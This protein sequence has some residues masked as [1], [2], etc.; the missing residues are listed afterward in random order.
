M[1]KWRK[2]EKGRLY[3][4]NDHENEE[5]QSVLPL[6]S[7]AKLQKNVPCH[8]VLVASNKRKQNF[9]WVVAHYTKGKIFSENW[10]NHIFAF[11]VNFFE[12]GGF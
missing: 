3:R 2:G 8:T 10:S 5:F 1:Q 7:R 11:L 9:G 4:S 12:F 6:H